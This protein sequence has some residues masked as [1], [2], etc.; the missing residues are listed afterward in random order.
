VKIP[1]ARP[2]LT[3]ADAEAVAQVLRTTQLSMGPQTDEFE[4]AFA[5]A[6]GTPYAVAVSSGTAGLHLSVV[7]A[8]VQDGDWVITTPF[9]FVASAN[10]I[11]YERAV[12][13]FVDIDPRTL[14]IAPAAVEEAVQ[15]LVA[16]TPQARRW[17]PRSSRGRGPE[18][19]R[20][21]AI[22][23]VHA[24]GRAA[25]MPRIMDTAQ[26]YGLG[27]IEDACEALGARIGSRGVGT[28]GDAGVF[29]FYPNKQIT[30]GEGGMVVTSRPEWAA[31]LRSL[32]NQGRGESDE[33][34]SHVRL[35]YNYRIDEM[36]AALGVAQLRRLEDLLS[37]R[38]RVANWYG[39]RL[40]DLSEVTLP[41]PAAEQE[42]L[43]WFVY[44]IQLH[45][46]V[47]RQAVRAA[48]A[49]AGIDSRPYF[50][51][52]HLQPFY[53]QRFGFREGDFPVTESVAGRTLALPFFATMTEAEV[54]YVCEHLARSV[55]GQRVRA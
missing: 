54:D 2:D 13:I 37:R 41:Q 40:S 17:L 43:S 45:D 55:A 42:R 18:S 21:K 53:R 33:W 46:S 7:A 22:L 27:V 11:L 20:L 12:P 35:G 4:Q 32:R 36:S 31:L 48:L 15:D 23:P 8:G 52:I 3:A 47:D 50:I 29:A 24:F 6:V 19:G 14:N 9:S 28:W 5:H 39:E 34:L 30:T 38:E 51:P 25:A 44:V 16:D 26:R 10:V 1:M 49:D